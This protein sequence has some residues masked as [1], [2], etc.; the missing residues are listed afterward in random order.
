MPQ[1]VIEVETGD[2]TIVGTRL[3]LV[4]KPDAGGDAPEYPLDRPVTKTKAAGGGPF[5]YTSS[6]SLPAGDYGLQIVL[7]GSGRSA[8]ATVRSGALIVPP[9]GQW[10]FAVEVPADRTQRSATCWFRA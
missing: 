2:D 10:P 9:G 1:I 3:V 8:K 5:L 6:A 7:K 4:G